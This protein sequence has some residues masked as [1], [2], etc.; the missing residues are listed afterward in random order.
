MIVGSMNAFCIEAWISPLEAQKVPSAS[1]RRLRRSGELRRSLLRLVEGFDN[2]YIIVEHIFLDK[3][4]AYYA[5]LNN[6]A[7]N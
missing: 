2:E 6:Q 5:R 4:D 7:I 3:N 1:N